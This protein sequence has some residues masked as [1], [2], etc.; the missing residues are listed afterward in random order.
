MAYQ[1][2]KMI[3]R[4]KRILRTAQALIA[5]KE[6][7]FTM[8]ELADASEVAEGTL[9]NLFGCQDALLA[10]AVANV[11]AER[12]DVP[13]SQQ[14]AANIA[15][16]VRLRNQASFAEMMRV[17]GYSKT[18]ARIYFG[19]KAGN[20]V[21]KTLHDAAAGFWSSELRKAGA[22]GDLYPWA[23]PDKL[24]GEIVT[25]TYAA[26]LRWADGELTDTEMKARIDFVTYA[27]LASGLKGESHKQ[28]IEA[29]EALTQ[30][31]PQPSR[32]RA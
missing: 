25:A 32:K 22:K 3:A 8:R 6:S 9:Y 18:M 4:R 27:L 28:I 19:A 24:A 2:P 15:E 11:F 26:I 5:E 29:I 16:A 1:S 31:T 17:P 13:L 21:R 23:D 10:E 12:M 7:N 14:H 20:D 30:E